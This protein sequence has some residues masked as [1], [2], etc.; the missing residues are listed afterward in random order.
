M[1][2]DGSGVYSLPAGTA[3]VAN[4]PANSAHVN[5]RFADLAADANSPRP[6]TAGGTGASSAA[7][8]LTN[9]G[10][11]ATAAELNALD[12]AIGDQAI[13][14]TGTDTVERLISAAKLDAKIPAKLNASGAAPLYACRAWVNFNGTG[15]V[16]IRASGNVSSITD[17]GTGDYTVNF[18]IAMPDANFGAIVTAGGGGVASSGNAAVGWGGIYGAGFL[19]I[20]TSDNNT[21]TNTDFPFINVAI[22]R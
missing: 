5:G 19:R 17:N 6:I 20:G 3:A 9:L 12:G 22:F 1:P 16:A 2:R 4:T 15:T 11:T 8:A 7:G 18:T 21:D 13:W 14:N 10:I